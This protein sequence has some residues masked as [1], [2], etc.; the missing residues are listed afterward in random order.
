LI[1]LAF[2]LPLALYL[3]VLG[4]IN[5]RRRPMMVSGTWDFIGVLFAASGFLLCG[6]PGVLGSLEYRWRMFWLTGQRG[7]GPGGAEG[8]WQFWVFLSALYFLVV[9]AGSAYLLLRQRHLTAVYNVERRAVE[10]ALIQVC[11]RLG[12]RPERSGDLFLFGMSAPA[13]PADSTAKRTGL[14]EPPGEGVQPGPYLPAG[15]PPAD[16]RVQGAAKGPPGGLIPAGEFLGQMATLQLDDF[17]LMRH[18]TLR[19]EPAE[20]PLRQEVEGALAGQLAETPAA[21]GELGAWLLLLGLFLL[22]F[23]CMG[24][25]ALLLYSLLVH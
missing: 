9:V 10:Q 7:A 5:R 15:E 16:S 12:L 4:A 2:F 1:L 24:G 11:E 14:H 23:V 3:I 18:V 20:S 19:W 6:G 17:A 25:F 8:A 22:L 21:G 13:G